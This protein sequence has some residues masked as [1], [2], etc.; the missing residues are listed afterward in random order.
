VGGM[1]VDLIDNVALPQLTGV[2]S[3]GEL[4]NQLVDCGGVGTAVWGFIYDFCIADQ[5]IYQYISADDISKL[6]VNALDA[7][8]RLI[9]DKISK[10]DAPGMMSISDGACLAVENKGTTGHADTLMKGTWAL[11]LPVGVANMTLPGDFTGVLG[12]DAPG[13]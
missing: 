13:R 8:G 7:V 6:C 5:C 9:E 1:L 11:T 2:N 10:L 4:L 3:I 12:P